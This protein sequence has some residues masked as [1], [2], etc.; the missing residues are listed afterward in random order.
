M[1]NFTHN[2]APTS[3]VADETS[4]QNDDIINCAAADISVEVDGISGAAAEITAELH[5]ISGVPAEISEEH[6]NVRLDG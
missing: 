1:Y 6:V 5:D 3:G 2:G 4:Q